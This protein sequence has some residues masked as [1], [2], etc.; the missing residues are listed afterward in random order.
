[1]KGWKKSLLI[2]FV[3]ALTSEFYLSFFVS[4]FRV[5]P[6]VIIFPILLMTVGIEVPVIPNAVVTSALIFISR[7]GLQLFS[8][9]PFA[10]AAR[11]VFPATFFYTTYGILFR[12][13]VRD[14]YAAS[15]MKVTAAAFCC[16][17][18][19]NIIEL[20]LQ[21]SMQNVPFA[22]DSVLKLTAIAAVRA[23]L[24]WGFLLLILWYR[25]YLALEEHE[26]RYQRMYMLTTSLKGEIY[27]MRQNTGQI[28]RVMGNAY[29]LYED[30]LARDMPA[31]MQQ[32]GL[33]IAREVHEIKKNYLRIIQG[34]EEELGKEPEDEEI[35]LS[36]I[37]RI[38]LETARTTISKKQ[39]QVVVQA[40][41]A[42]DFPVREHYSL[43]SILMNLVNNAIEA[44]ETDQKKGTIQVGEVKKEGRYCFEVKDDGPG[45]SE[46]HLKN[47]FKM[48]YS[49][50]F[51]SRTGN[52][53]RGVGLCGVKNLVE[54]IL[55]GNIRVESEPGKGTV[56]YVEIPADMLEA[57]AEE[58]TS[59]FDNRGKIE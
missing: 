13:L 54:D 28:E 11:A 34:I 58:D 59:G 26:K 22:A 35:R 29:R 32:T 20:Q 15:I 53:F 14:R 33:D 50:K 39:L 45:I 42:D 48:G 12:F 16:D 1:M 18:L 46:R 49:T 47:I 37:I 24:V 3:I 56:F 6:S 17:L 10:Q 25:T 57:A 40:E 9:V 51:D 21:E 55:G 4:N 43:M 41:A 8:G 19:S 31:Q 27:L 23:A 44:I 7:A 36:E 38:L 30:L 52:I 5:S 2:G